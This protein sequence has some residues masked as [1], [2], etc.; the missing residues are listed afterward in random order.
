LPQ[1]AT[2]LET[3]ELGRLLR[4]LLDEVDKGDKQ[5]TSTDVG[6]VKTNQLAFVNTKVKSIYLNKQLYL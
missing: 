1:E 5:Q 2:K 3:T 6:S 4:R